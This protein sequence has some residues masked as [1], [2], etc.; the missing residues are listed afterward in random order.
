MFCFKSRIGLLC[1]AALLLTS[2]KSFA[3]VEESPVAADDFVRGEISMFM[4][5]I[6]SSD[7][8]RFVTLRHKMQQVM[9]FDKFSKS[10]MGSKWN[11]T[12]AA[13]KRKFVAALQSL[14]ES[15][16]INRPANVFVSNRMTVDEVIPSGANTAVRCTIK[17]SDVDIE[18]MIK[19]SP[20]GS[21]W[22]IED[23]TVDGLGLIEDYRAQFQSFLK[24]K[25][26][27]QLITRLQERAA[28]NAR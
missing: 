28:A 25:T 12:S 13:D 17:Q 3:G 10:V 16:Y 1:A 14:M 8:G 22:Q 11:T 9:D 18:V 23:V 27:D 24:R 5:T 4:A 20:V 21:S 15:Y 2:I 7:P 26:L 19:L 6:R